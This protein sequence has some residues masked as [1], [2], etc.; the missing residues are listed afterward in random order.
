MTFLDWIISAFNNLIG[1]LGRLFAPLFNLIGTGFN[2]LIHFLEK[3]LSLVYYFF[4][5]VFYFIAQLFNVLVLVIK[6]FT[7]FFQFLGAIFTGVFRTIQMWLIPGLS[8][9]PAYPSA[10]EQGFQTFFDVVSPTGLTTVIPV[11]AI[12]FC[13]FYFILKIISLFG[14]EIYVRGFGDGSGKH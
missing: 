3:P 2:N 1:F 14:G 11:I 10:S 4:D 12:A 9:S 13:W 6:I 5:G 7:A 8:A